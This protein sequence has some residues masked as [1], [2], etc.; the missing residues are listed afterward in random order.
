[1]SQSIVYLKICRHEFANLLFVKFPLSLS[2]SIPQKALF[3]S[4][5]KRRSAGF[6]A[7]PRVALVLDIMQVHRRKVRFLIEP[8]SPTRFIL[9]QIVGYTVSL[10]PF[11][12]SMGQTYGC[13]CAS[14][15]VCIHIVYVLMRYFGVSRDSGL[16]WQTSL[17]RSQMSTLMKGRIAPRPRPTLTRIASREKVPRAPITDDDVC[18]ICYDG[19]TGGKAEEIA[20]CS[21]KCRGNFHR[22]CVQA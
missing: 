18:P 11:I 12:V 22:D 20:W 4:L 2:I 9:C 15:D 21:Y 8:R 17:T 16:L 14:R 10:A 13:S 7:Q 5:G 1:M 6:A 19:M 3:L